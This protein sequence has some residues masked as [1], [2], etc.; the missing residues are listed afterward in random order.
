LS[1]SSLS[2]ILAEEKALY[3]KVTHLWP[4]RIYRLHVVLDGGGEGCKAELI[5]HSWTNV[6]AASR[7][8]P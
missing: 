7:L 6:G 4:D 3:R 5:H 2:F 8:P 1:S